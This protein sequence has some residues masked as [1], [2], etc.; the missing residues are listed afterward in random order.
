MQPTS[1]TDI[2]LTIMAFALQR[3]LLPGSSVISAGFRLPPPGEVE[4]AA[5]RTNCRTC[6]RQPVFKPEVPLEG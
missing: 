6:R 3:K 1:W 2:A 5:R 4:C